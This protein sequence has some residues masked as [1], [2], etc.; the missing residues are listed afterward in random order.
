MC[1]RNTS[2]A[3][4][5]SSTPTK[6]SVLNIVHLLP[7]LNAHNITFRGLTVTVSAAKV[8]HNKSITSETFQRINNLTRMLLPYWTVSSQ[9]DILTGQ[10]DNRRADE[11]VSQRGGTDGT[12]DSR[13]LRRDFTAQ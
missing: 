10:R 7:K 12:A 2:R 5:R 13:H 3:Y 1:N 4:R 11:H 8:Y 9:K 6:N